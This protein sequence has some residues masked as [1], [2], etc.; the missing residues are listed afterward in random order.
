[1]GEQGIGLVTHIEG[2]GST[3]R[4]LECHAQGEICVD[5]DTAIN[6]WNN[7]IEPQHRHGTFTLSSDIVTAY[8]EDPNYS[9][10]Q[11]FGNF[12]I[13][14]AKYDPIARVYEYLAYSHLFDDVGAVDVPPKYEVTIHNTGFGPDVTCRRIDT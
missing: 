12:V 1:M 6:F 14:N 7:R 9:L 3:V 13:I 4:C 11:V 10:E 2:Q 8:R 5:E